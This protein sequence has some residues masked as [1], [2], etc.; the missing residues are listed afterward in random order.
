MKIIH[1][2]D[3]SECWTVEERQQFRFRIYSG[4][5]VG[6]YFVSRREILVNVIQCIH[7]LLEETT[8]SLEPSLNNTV[9]RLKEL[10]PEDENDHVKIWEYRDNIQAVWEDRAVQVGTGIWFLYFMFS[11]TKA[12]L[13]P[14]MAVRPTVRSFILNQNKS[15]SHKPSFTHSIMHAINLTTPH[16]SIH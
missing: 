16:T 8:D 5:S 10:K 4:I 15:P 1:S 14:Q 6:K 13:E 3:K 9:T 7:I 11:V 2:D 12:T